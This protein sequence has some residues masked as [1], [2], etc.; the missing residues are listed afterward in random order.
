MT[1]MI[2]VQL[3]V[4]DY[5]FFWLLDHESVCTVSEISVCPSGVGCGTTTTTSDD[6]E[7]LPPRKKCRKMTRSKAADVDRR[8]H[9]DNAGK[10]KTK[11][12]G[13]KGRK[14]P[15][16]QDKGKRGSHNTT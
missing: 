6:E 1:L 2:S 16:R 14:K 13:D 9:P 3:E 10:D 11:G 15:Q 8:D 12:K 5:A 4:A 7:G